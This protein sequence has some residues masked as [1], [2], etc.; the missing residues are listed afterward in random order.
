MLNRLE[1]LY[2]DVFNKNTVWSKITENDGGASQ[3]RPDCAI[4]TTYDGCKGM[5]RDVCVLFD[6]TED[7]WYLRLDKPNVRYEILRNIFCVA[8]SRGKKKI[9]FVETDS[10]PLTYEVLMDDES[11][12]ASFE[13]MQMSSM[14]DFKFIEDVEAAFKALSVTEIQPEEQPILQPEFRDEPEPKPELESVPEEKYA[15]EEEKRKRSDRPRRRRRSGNHGESGKENRSEKPQHKEKAE[16]SENS[17][18]PEK[19][20]ER[21]PHRDRRSGGEK[22]DKPEKRREPWENKPAEGEFMDAHRQP[23]RRNPRRRGRDPEHG[24]NK[25]NKPENKTES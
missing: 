13:D 22:A 8:A 16:R 21:R 7:Y 10:A 17:D 6:W 19:R 15:P 25:E 18:K 20:R 4:F 14:F 11:G 3:P 5:E 12:H 23:K 9:V 1:V 24:K 2:P